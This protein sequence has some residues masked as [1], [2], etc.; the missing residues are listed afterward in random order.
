V[1]SD[2][3]LRSLEDERED[4]KALR[5]RQEQTRRKEKGERRKEKGERAFGP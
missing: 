2:R 5:E 4:A 3:W 1:P